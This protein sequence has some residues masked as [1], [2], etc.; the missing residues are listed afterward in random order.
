MRDQLNALAKRAN[1]ITNDLKT[2]KADTIAAGK[3]SVDPTLTQAQRDLAKLAYDALKEEYELL[4]DTLQDTVSEYNRLS[5]E[6]SKFQSLVNDF[7]NYGIEFDRYYGLPDGIDEYCPKLDLT[8][9][10]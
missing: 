4:V 5:F 8:N 1:D 6:Y 10:L 3:R 7:L 9:T 2:N